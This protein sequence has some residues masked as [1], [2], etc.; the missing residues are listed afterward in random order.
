MNIY[1]LASERSRS[2]YTRPGDDERLHVVAVPVEGSSRCSDQQL[3]CL[4]HAMPDPHVQTDR[5]SSMR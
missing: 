2:N 5:L 3:C 4:Q 1:I